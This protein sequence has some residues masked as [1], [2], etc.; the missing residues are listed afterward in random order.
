[1]HRTEFRRQKPD[2]GAI[3]V[4][5]GI[6]L[7][8]VGGLLAFSLNVGNMM[9]SRAALHL[10]TDAAALAGA[11]SING[12][13]LGLESISATANAFAT[14]HFLGKEQVII[15]PAKDIETGIW[16]FS[17]ATFTPSTEPTLVNAVRVSGGRDSS[18]DHNQALAVH[19]GAFLGDKTTTNVRASSIAVGGGPASSCSV[20]LVLAE[21]AVT[22]GSGGG[23]LQCD[24]DLH[25]EFN[26]D[27]DD[28][29]GFTNLGGEGSVNTDSIRGLLNGNSGETHC[30]TDP[31]TGLPCCR[32]KSGDSLKVGNG[33]NLNKQVENAF[34]TPINGPVGGYICNGSHC[35][36]VTVPIIKADCKAGN[37]KFNGAN[38]V[39]G[40]ATFNIKKVSDH[41][42]YIDIHMLCNRPS[43]DTAGGVSFG[44]AGRPRLVK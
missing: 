15:T 32:V 28:N 12:T 31:A 44:T 9:H 36:A 33:S 2:E 39:I 37:P 8:A 27:K 20:P 41:P 34:E 23:G 3:A 13:S 26:N 18:G 7:L 14:S 35:P 21:C 38:E 4:L 10:A 42:R 24:Q 43:T 5:A 25:L 40:F 17:L 11:G 16:S 29:V 1:M 22:G 30:S 19:F 6:S